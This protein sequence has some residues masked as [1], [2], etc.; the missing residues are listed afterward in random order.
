VLPKLEDWVVGGLGCFELYYIVVGSFGVGSMRRVMG[1]MVTV[2]F[3][4][5]ELGAAVSCV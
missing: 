1:L 3:S 4:S 2:L 5:S